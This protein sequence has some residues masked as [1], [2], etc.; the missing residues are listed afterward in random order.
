MKFASLKEK[1]TGQVVRKEIQCTF[2]FVWKI[3]FSFKL[4][5]IV[6]LSPH[7][8]FTSNYYP[9][10]LLKLCFWSLFWN[11]LLLLPL[12]DHCLLKLLLLSHCPLTP[13]ISVALVLSPEALTAFPL[14]LEVAIS[15]CGPYSSGCKVILGRMWFVLSVKNPI[16]NPSFVDWWVL[17]CCT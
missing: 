1:G 5:N 13:D 7:K 3:M 2:N 10:A 15:F 14:S 12:P 16:F 4:L 17:H 8:S 11:L 6:L 9:N